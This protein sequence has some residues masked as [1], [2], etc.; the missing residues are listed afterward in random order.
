MKSEK[1]TAVVGPNVFF[2]GTA[3]AKPTVA[4][5][6][7]RLVTYV[8]FQPAI[9][10]QPF[11]VLRIVGRKGEHLD[12]LNNPQTFQTSGWWYGLTT[13]SVVGNCD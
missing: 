4:F 2:T 9:E 5:E 7:N 12:I 11:S 10:K 3:K 6:S 1:S 13:N 8:E